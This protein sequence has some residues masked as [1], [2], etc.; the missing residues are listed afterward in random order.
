VSK[1]AIQLECAFRHSVGSMILLSLGLSIALSGGGAD[2]NALQRRRS[3]VSCVGRCFVDTPVEDV[4]SGACACDHLCGDRGECCGDYNK[5]CALVRAYTVA[6][7]DESPNGDGAVLRARRADG[8]DDD[9][10]DFDNLRAG[11]TAVAT[12]SPTADVLQLAATG[13]QAYSGPMVDES[14]AIEGSGG[15]NTGHGHTFAAHAVG[16]AMA[17]AVLGAVVAATMLV[18]LRRR[19]EQHTLSEA[20][21]VVPS[22]VASR[23]MRS[24][25]SRQLSTEL[26]SEGTLDE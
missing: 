5:L 9:V 15:G 23:R 21:S 14:V 3:A 4:R 7:Y 11:G 8:D 24:R 22:V 6:E 2:A 13:D 18:S 10:V 20:S 26:S 16:I 25:V 19:R 17:V 1:R 12:A